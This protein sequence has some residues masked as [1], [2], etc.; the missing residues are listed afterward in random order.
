MHVR[1]FPRPCK[2]HCDLLMCR[3]RR[4]RDVS[5]SKPRAKA[6]GGS[7]KSAGE[8]DESETGSANEEAPPGASSFS[9]PNAAASFPRRLDLE[10]GRDAPPAALDRP[11][12]Q[13]VPVVDL[14]LPLP[15]V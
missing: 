3:L 12:R 11:R 8:V 2:P 10:C 7:R 9:A 14:L 5:R 6:V 1:P 13:V 15:L 4:V